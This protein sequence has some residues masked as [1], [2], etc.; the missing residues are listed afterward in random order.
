MKRFITLVV[1][2]ILVLGIAVPVLTVLA[3]GL[4]P[5][6]LAEVIRHPLYRQGLLMPSSSPPW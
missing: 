2:L 4:D 3:G 1:G 5:F 6:Y